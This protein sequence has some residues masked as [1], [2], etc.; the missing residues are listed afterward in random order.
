MVVVVVLSN[1]KIM[2]GLM[3]RYVVIERKDAA[4]PYL[5]LIMFFAYLYFKGASL[6]ELSVLALLSGILVEI[7]SVARSV[8][9]IVDVVEDD[10]S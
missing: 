8:I 5:F 10:L 1:S 4:F 9:R 6:F 3:K 2:E 7:G